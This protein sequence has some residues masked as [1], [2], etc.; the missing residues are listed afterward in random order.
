MA[1]K[2]THARIDKMLITKKNTLLPNYTANDIFK[3]GLSTTLGLEKAGRFIYGDLWKTPNN[4]KTKK[5]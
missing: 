5:R 1:K 2:T 4:E 3:V